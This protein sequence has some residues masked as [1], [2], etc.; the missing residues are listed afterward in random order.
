ME[1]IM[2]GME[3]VSN[4]LWGP[5]TPWVLLG[6]GLL[7]TIWSRFT[8]YTALTHGFAVVRGKYDDPNDPGAINHF[9]ALSA[10]LSATVGLGNIGG[11]AL[12]I[13]MGGPGALFWMWIVGLLGMAL[14]SVEITLAMMYRNVDDPENPHGG[15]MWVVDKVLGSKGG[16]WVGIAKGIGIFFCITLLISSFTGGNMFQSWS[17]TQLTEGYFGVSKWTT[18]I[19]MA[20]LVGMVIIGGIKRIGSVAGKLVPFMC[21]TYLVAAFAVLGVN[22]GELPAMFKLVFTSAFNPTEATG[23]FLGGSMGYAFMEG[24]KR[25]LF[26]NEAGQGSAPIA[27]AAAKTDEPAREGIVGGMPGHSGGGSASAFGGSGGHI[28]MFPCFREIIAK[29]WKGLQQALK[30]GP[31]FAILCS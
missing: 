24:M 27:H 2:S 18:G 10:A 31:E 29:S 17:V 22:I 7:F 8:Q 23:A 28:A 3:S 12:A 14:K 6:T 15:A 26:S 21:A 5:W 20:V 1:T 19:I 11:V 30:E 25:A 13:G 4:F 9:E 16:V